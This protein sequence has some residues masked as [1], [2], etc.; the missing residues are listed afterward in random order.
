MRILGIDYGRKKLG[1]AIGDKETKFAEPL[2][3]IRYSSPEEGFTKTEQIV[4]VEQ[5]GQVV[6]GV[7]EGLSAEEAKNFGEKLK[8]V[9]QIPVFYFDETLSTME[10]QKLSLEAGI[11]RKKRKSMEDAY[12]AALILQN[13]LE[14]C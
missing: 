1:I 14:A 12:A 8:K 3:V 9:I 6:I 7:S 5:A 2:S 13:Y 4:K 10:A 11:K